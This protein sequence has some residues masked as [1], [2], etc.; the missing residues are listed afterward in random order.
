MAA[1]DLYLERTSIADWAAVAGAMRCLEIRIGQLLGPARAGG[2]SS[3]TEGAD[4][5]KD[6]RSQ[7]RKMAAHPDIVQDVIEGY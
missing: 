1:I 2:H 5:S 3:A 4:L 7:S 6:E